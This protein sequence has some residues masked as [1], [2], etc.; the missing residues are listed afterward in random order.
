MDDKSQISYMK[1]G[2]VCSSNMSAKAP[3]KHE[4]T[5]S[6]KVASE[7]ASVKSASKHSAVAG[8]VQ[9]QSEPKHSE[10]SQSVRMDSKG[11]KSLSKHPSERPQSEKTAPKPLESAG[12]SSNKGSVLGSIRQSSQRPQSVNQRSS[13]S[14]YSL[15]GSVKSKEPEEEDSSNSFHSDHDASQAIRDAEQQELSSE[16]E[17]ENSQEAWCSWTYEECTLMLK[18]FPKMP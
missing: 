18:R 14:Q 5:P 17:S 1:H 13:H 8:S 7:R 12:I 11:A 2:S 9:A 16:D 10:K 15:K 3:S 6:K 4:N